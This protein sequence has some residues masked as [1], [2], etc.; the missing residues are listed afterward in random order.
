M[1]IQCP[2]LLLVSVFAFLSLW[3]RAYA[4]QDAASVE[5]PYYGNDQGG[6]R[7]STL[8]QINRGN[9]SRLA[10]AWTY[11]TGDISDGHTDPDIAGGRYSFNK[12]GFENT[13]IVVD[14]TMYITTP[15]CRVIALD[16]ETGKEKWSYD[17]QIRR[18]KPYSEGL[19]NRGV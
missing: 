5:W 13:P 16:P 17:P 2:R 12:T 18:D 7:Y 11:H 4:G 14:G 8:D 6:Q 19:I 9:V 3:S 15:F 1:K 10:V